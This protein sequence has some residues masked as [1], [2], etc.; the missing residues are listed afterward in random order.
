MVFTL[1]TLLSYS[2]TE[3]DDINF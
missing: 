2:F 1:V 3:V